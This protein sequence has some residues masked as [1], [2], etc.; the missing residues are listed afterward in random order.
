MS[1]EARV[2][3]GQ[4]VARQGFADAGARRAADVHAAARDDRRGDRNELRRPAESRRDE[5]LDDVGSTVVGGRVADNSLYE[6]I[7]ERSP[8]AM[9]T[10]SAIPSSPATCSCA[11]HEA[12]DAAQLIGLRA[13]SQRTQSRRPASSRTASAPRCASS[14]IRA[15]ATGPGELSS[16]DAVPSYPASRSAVRYGTRMGV[17]PV[18]AGRSPCR[19]PSQSAMWTCPIRPRSR[20]IP[21]GSMRC[22]QR[23]EMSIAAVTPGSRPR[24]AASASNR[25]C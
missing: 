14:P 5:R 23:W 21:A 20:A 17:V 8:E 13:T 1:T 16:T 3:V 9:S 25:G 24:R 22:S 7:V 4:A 19:T 10:T 18:P 2:L 12:A 11:S 15:S 6:A